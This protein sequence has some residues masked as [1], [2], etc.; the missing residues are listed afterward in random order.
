M[1]KLENGQL[2]FRGIYI[3]PG[4]NIGVMR[5]HLEEK[6]GENSLSLTTNPMEYKYL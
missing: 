1:E 3:R 5:R 2:K 4:G 6:T